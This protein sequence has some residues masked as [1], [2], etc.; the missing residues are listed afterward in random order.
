MEELR[1][2]ERGVCK[3]YKNNKFGKMRKY[4]KKLGAKSEEKREMGA[5]SHN[6]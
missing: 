6:H 4:V 1:G 2:R 3:A 5:I